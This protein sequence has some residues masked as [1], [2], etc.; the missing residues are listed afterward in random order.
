MNKYSICLCND[1]GHYLEA[2]YFEFQNECLVFHRNNQPFSI[3]A[4]FGA[5][6]IRSIRLL[7]DPIRFPERPRP[8]NVD[9][10][11]EGDYTE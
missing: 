8:F 7:D 3:V 5:S 11:N 10:N 2:D 4:V 9:A 6:E 1:D